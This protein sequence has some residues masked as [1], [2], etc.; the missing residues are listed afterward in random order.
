MI[1]GRILAAVVVAVLVGTARAQTYTVDPLGGAAD[2]TDL[3]KALDTVPP[4]ATLLVKFGSWT[5]IHVK[6]PVT[7]IG[8]P[9][10]KIAA[11]EPSWGNPFVQA[12][13]LTLAGP[14]SGTVV[15]MNVTTGGSTDGVWFSV[16]GEGIAGG[17]FTE[18]EL[19]HCDIRPPSWTTLT[20]LGEGADAIDLAGVLSVLAVDTTVTGGNS[21]TDACNYFQSYPGG[22][23]IDAPGATV[24]LLDSTVVGGSVGLMCFDMGFPPAMGPCPCPG[25]G[26]EG[27]IGIQASQLFHAQSDVK[28]G[29]GA[30]VEWGPPATP[31]GSQPDGAATAGILLGVDLGNGLN[32]GGPLQS[33]QS[34]DLMWTGQPAVLAVSLGAVPT[35]QPLGPQGWLYLDL[36]GPFFTLPVAPG[37]TGTSFGIPSSPVLVGLQV[38]VQAWEP[39]AGLRRPVIDRIAP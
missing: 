32:A 15:L 17:G 18:L 4:G 33:G 34:W 19:Y 1:H 12:P 30:D 26:G 5:A 28:G 7:I 21:D 13:A 3:Q 25:F 31:F 38:A 35:P 22:E 9:L 20:G 16:Q 8:D 6:Q 36:A 39:W 14:G 24:T 23:G 29:Q 10:T 37:S 11:P 27:G 2:F